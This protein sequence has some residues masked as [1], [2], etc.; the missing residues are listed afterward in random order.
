MVWAARGSGGRRVAAVLAAP[1]A[2][3]SWRQHITRLC[4]G[5]APTCNVFKALWMD[6]FVPAA[7]CTVA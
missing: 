3:A 4:A 2:P 5:Q 7:C 1:R 6:A